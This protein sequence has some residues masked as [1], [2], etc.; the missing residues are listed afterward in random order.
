[1]TSP[2]GRVETL[3]AA[4]AILLSLGI[5]AAI[6]WLMINSVDGDVGNVVAGGLVVSLKDTIALFA[7]SSEPAAPPGAPAA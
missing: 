7:R 6:M 5:V 3:R 4:G 1:M 2:N